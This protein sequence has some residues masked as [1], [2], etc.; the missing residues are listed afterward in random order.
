MA[1][2]A[3]PYGR[4]YPLGVSVPL[5][6]CSLASGRRLRQKLLRCIAHRARSQFLPG[7]SFYRLSV[8]TA[9]PPALRAESEIPPPAFGRPPPFLKG[10]LGTVDPHSN[11]GESG[12]LEP[13]TKPVAGQA[14]APLHFL[15]PRRGSKGFTPWSV[16]GYFLLIKKVTIAGLPVRPE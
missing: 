12:G 4:G 3:P 16:F 6:R 8:P 10:G 7:A 9:W 5:L 2:F 14:G 1:A 11:Q 13:S 15:S